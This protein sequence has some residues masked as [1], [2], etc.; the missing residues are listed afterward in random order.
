MREPNG[1]QLFAIARLARESYKL[2]A[3]LVEARARVRLLLTDLGR[4]PA[5][6]LFQAL[7]GI[8]DLQLDVGNLLLHVRPE[9]GGAFGLGLERLDGLMRQQLCP[10]ALR[11]V[12]PL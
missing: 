12:E 9:F 6:G 3:E 8:G 10:G 11:V 7:G 2:T 1:E 5:G 4:V